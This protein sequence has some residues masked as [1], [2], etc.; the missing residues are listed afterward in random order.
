MKGEI[1]PAQR[2]PNTRAAITAGDFALR[3][4][5]ALDEFVLEAAAPPL[6]IPT[7]EQPLHDDGFLAE[8][9][10]EVTGTQDENEDELNIDLD[11]TDA[12]RKLT[13]ETTT[14]EEERGDVWDLVA[15]TQR[16]DTEAFADIYHQY[17]DTVFRFVYYRVGNRQIAE[18]LTS[19]AFLRGLRRI[20]SVEWRGRDLGAWFVTI[21]RNLV[22]DYF[23]SGRYRFEVTT[24]DVL[25]GNDKA[26]TSLYVNPEA[27]VLEH[28][29]NLTLLDAV[30]RLN[31]EQRQCLVLRFLQGYSVA[32][33]AQ[34][35]GKNEGAI[36]ALQYRATRTLG[37]LL[38]E[39]FTP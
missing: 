20:E 19:E 34:I 3:P 4:G 25:D 13:L 21:A 14:Q 37:R 9:P 12:D 11:P 31:A 38:P 28:I 10:T 22:A 39:G 24:G 33:T 36:K 35:M 16:G 5:I 1:V 15:R 18:D 8:I 2:A 7:Q 26:D 32:E 27:T 29:T 17:L 23:K 30:Q 6:D